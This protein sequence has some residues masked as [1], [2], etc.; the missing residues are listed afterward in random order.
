MSDAT[1]TG[2][3]PATNSAPAQQKLFF[4]RA[5]LPVNGIDT[6]DNYDD[7]MTEINNGWTVKC[8]ETVLQD[9]THGICYV[10]VQLTK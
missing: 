1:P 4:F 8:Y 3:P 2:S 5:W 9:T 6:K 10:L 7:L